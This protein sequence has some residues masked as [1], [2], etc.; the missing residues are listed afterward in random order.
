MFR[1]EKLLKSFHEGVF[2]VAFRAEKHSVYVGAESSISHP[3]F[4]HFNKLEEYDQL[5]WWKKSSKWTR[6]YTEKCSI[7]S[8]SLIVL[9]I[10]IKKFAGKRWNTDS[11]VFLRWE[12]FT[13]NLHDLRYFMCERGLRVTLFT[14]YQNHLCKAIIL[15]ILDEWRIINEL[16]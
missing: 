15:F 5:C 4:K 8:L 3:A 6:I 1:D 7:H 14:V 16:L 11:S 2:I 12:Y 10:L 13:T 9:N